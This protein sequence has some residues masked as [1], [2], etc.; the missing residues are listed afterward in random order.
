MTWRAAVVALSCAAAG[1]CAGS[2][3]ARH[4]APYSL[5]LPEG[6]TAPDSLPENTQAMSVET[7]DPVPSV[8]AIEERILRARRLY[9]DLAF[10]ASLEE[11]ERAQADAEA[12]LPVDE[13]TSLLDR[14]HLLRALDHLALGE[15]EEASTALR[16]AVIL[17]PGRDGLDPAEYSPEVRAA[18]DAERK[19]LSTEGAYPLDAESD[20]LASV[21]SDGRRAGSTPLVLRL[22]RGRH[23]LV[24]RAPRY[25]AAL[26]VVDIDEASELRLRVELEALRPT[27]VAGRLA[28]L[29]APE[30]AALPS[31]ERA[32]LV[33]PGGAAPVHVGRDDGGWR[34]ALIDPSTGAIVRSV[35]T[36]IDELDLAVPELVG[37]LRDAP[38]KKPL[39]R[40]W[41]FWTAIGAAVVATSL[42]LYFGLRKQPETQLVIRPAAP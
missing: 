21:S 30:L 15:P 3:T 42:G 9:R 24:F 29:S 41:W 20:P 39:V 12:R 16:Q 1:G 23:Y 18:Y 40:K 26:H 38:Q 32:G 37:S 28:G 31:A 10:R 25:A 36:E 13:T 33:S 6:S 17:A 34:A 11:L 14:I 8:A 22:H 35:G 27:E 2:S 7:P 4:A 5:L 19:A